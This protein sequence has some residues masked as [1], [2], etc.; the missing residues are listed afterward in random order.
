M[1]NG[2]M[3]S[4]ETPPEEFPVYIF[5][6]VVFQETLFN[7]KWIWQ[8]WEPTMP[9]V[10][11]CGDLDHAAWGLQGGR[12]AGSAGRG[13]CGPQ[14]TQDKSLA[15]RGSLLITPHLLRTAFFS[16]KTLTGKLKNKILG[17]YVCVCCPYPR[18]KRL[19][20]NHFK[21]TNLARKKHPKAP[22]Q[23]H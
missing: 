11:I 20:G 3:F 1:K 6:F 15:S 18:A 7:W 5:D 9:K 8:I 17:F 2:R 16:K 21:H 22:V 23:K 19:A 13:C 12:W 10:L 14:N 4:P